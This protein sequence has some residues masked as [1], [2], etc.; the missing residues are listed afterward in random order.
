MTSREIA[1]NRVMTALLSAKAGA[2]DELL[3]TLRGLVGDLQNLPGCT[4]CLLGQD[5]SGGP[6]FLLYVTWADAL[7]MKAAVSSEPFRVLLGAANTLSDHAR[8]R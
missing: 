7:A 2:Q 1:G 3:Q 5:V 4:A 6:H 8:F